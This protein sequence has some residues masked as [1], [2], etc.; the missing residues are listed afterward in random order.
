MPQAFGSRRALAVDWIPRWSV[1]WLGHGVVA[2]RTLSCV[3]WEPIP[4]T[5]STRLLRLSVSRNMFM[6]R[7]A[8]AGCPNLDGFLELRADVASAC[9][10]D[11]DVERV[12]HIG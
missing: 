1:H 7:E 2:R 5:L 11:D 3:R 12:K 10:R 4:R 6:L 9:D 8:Q